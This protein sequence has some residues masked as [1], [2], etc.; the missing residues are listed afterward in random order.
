VCSSDLTVEPN[1]RTALQA[2]LADA[3]KALTV[4]PTAPKPRTQP[5]PRTRGWIAPPGQDWYPPVGPGPACDACEQGCND[6]YAS[7]VDK[8]NFGGWLCFISIACA[9]AAFAEWLGCLGLCHLP[10]NACLPNPCG[11]F[12][13]CDPADKCFSYK[14]GSLCCT[15]P[16]VVCQDACCGKGVTNCLPDGSC[17]CSSEFNQIQC[18]NGCCDGNKDICSNGICCPKGQVNHEGK[19]YVEKNVCGA[20]CCDELRNAPIPRPACV[21]LSAPRLAAA[22]AATRVMCASMVSVALRSAV[23]AARAVPQVN[24][25]P[26]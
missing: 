20:I 15:A 2:L 8:G 17:G 3:T 18:G 9:A 13:T 4:C 19:C 22:N 16:G 26:T 25:A 6:T 10:G 5:A 11:T 1:L 21:V 7:N 12:T 23:A 14:D 24:T